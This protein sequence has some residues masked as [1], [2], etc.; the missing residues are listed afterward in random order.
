MLTHNEE[1]KE[2]NK[3][4]DSEMWEAMGRGTRAKTFIRRVLKLPS[5]VS[6]K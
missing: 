6:R 5:R 4:E 3:E 1:D 2:E